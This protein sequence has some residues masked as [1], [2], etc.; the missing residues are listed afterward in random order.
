[1]PQQTEHSSVAECRQALAERDEARRRAAELAR[2]RDEALE[3]SRLKSE[4][5]ANMSHEI[6]TPLNGVLGLADILLDGELNDDQREFV[7]TIRRCGDALMDVI[8]DILDVAKIEAGKLELEQ[9]DF[10]LRRVI[11]D[12]CAIVAPVAADKDLELMAWVDHDLPQ[13]VRGDGN[14]VRQVLVNLLNNAVKFTDRGEVVVRVSS[15]WKDGRPILRF[16]VRDTGVGIEPAALDGLFEPFTQVRPAGVAPRTGTGLGLTISKQL[17]DLMGGT[18]GADSLPGRGSTFFFSVPLAG[19]REACAPAPEIDLTGV[20]VLIADDNATNRE[21]L[22]HQ[23]TG[24]KMSSD[25]AHDGATALSMLRRATAEGRPYALVLLDRNMPGMHELEL[26]RTMRRSPGLAAVPILILSSAAAAGRDELR[27]AGVDG[28]LTKPVGHARLRDEIKRILGAAASPAPALAWAGMPADTAGAPRV[29]LAEDNEVNQMVAV[30]VLEQ[31]GYAVDIAHTGREAVEMSLR[32]GYDAILMDCRL[33]ELDGYSAAGEIRRLE[34]ADRHTPIIAVTAHTMSG[35]REKCLAA[36]MD[37]YIA[38]PLRRE[39]LQSVLRA[40]LPVESGHTGSGAAD[41]PAGDAVLV[42]NSLIAEFD[43]LSA[44]RITTLFVSGARERV[45]ELGQA[46]GRDDH[47]AVRR[48]AHGLKGAAA[49]V[50]A[51]A[52]CRACDRLSLAASAGRWTLAADC[53]GELERVLTQTEIALSPS[54]DG[55]R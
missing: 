35:D 13:M 6:R 47:K 12:A 39:T 37:E 17:V 5:V 29:L 42:D 41:P 49:S 27:R 46:V 9:E 2:A 55:Q 45:A 21:I 30:N 54:P 24:W 3:L 11:D 4:F 20:R 25:W 14:R 50:G 16:A 44:R 7:E 51:V 8:A 32:G 43:E 19:A 15:R 1:M 40:A 18:I 22:R 52:I 48:L 36:G 38:K 31:F 23:L 53:Q 33:P 28:V 34:A 10:E 26:V